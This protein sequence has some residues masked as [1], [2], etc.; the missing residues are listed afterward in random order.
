LDAVT[1]DCFLHYTYRVYLDV[2][3]MRT[4]CHTIVLLVKGMARQLIVDNL[5][6]ST[7]FSDQQ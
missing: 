6:K 2:S 3:P 4:R 5:L 1:V 7:E